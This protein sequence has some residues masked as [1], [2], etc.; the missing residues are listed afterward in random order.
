MVIELSLFQDLLV[1]FLKHLDLLLKTELAKVGL[2]SVLHFNDPVSDH[3]LLR[4]V[5]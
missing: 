3:L 1:F 2:Q 5:A 4:D